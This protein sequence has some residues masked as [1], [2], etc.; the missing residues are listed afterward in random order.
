MRQQNNVIHVIY[1]FFVKS[2]GLDWSNWDPILNW[3]DLIESFRINYLT[4]PMIKL[5][6]LDTEP[7]QPVRPNHN[8]HLTKSQFLIDY[9][10]SKSVNLLLIKMEAGRQCA[11]VARWPLEERKG[12]FEKERVRVTTKRARRISFLTS[13]LYRNQYNSKIKTK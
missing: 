8:Y 7:I 13:S 11:E 2:A 1:F 12:H 9:E 3:S 10:D 4:D 6:Q 5:V